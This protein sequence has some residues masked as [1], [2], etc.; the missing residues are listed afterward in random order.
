M[1]YV[2]AGD[3]KVWR[4][5]NSHN[6][7]KTWSFYNNNKCN[8]GTLMLRQVAGDNNVAAAGG[9]LYVIGDSRVNWWNGTCWFQMA[10]LP[11]GTPVDIAPH[12][13]GSDNTK[14]WAVNASGTIY[15]WTNSGWV[16]NAGGTGKGL[17]DAGWLIGSDGRS[18]W[19]QASAGP[20]YTGPWTF[21]RETTWTFGSVVQIGRNASGSFAATVAIRSDGQIWWYGNDN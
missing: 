21:T 3:N 13:Y 18:L 14:I 1:M 19:R 12:P 16:L 7:D 2:I 4:Q 11:S 6:S 17:S 20:A 10:A 9:A 5:D 8:G 15:Q